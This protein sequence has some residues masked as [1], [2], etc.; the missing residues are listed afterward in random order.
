MNST[1]DLPPEVISAIQA[2]QKIKAIKLLRGA[3]G[4]GLK[5]AKDAVD[6]YLE[7]NP[8]FQQPQANTNGLVFIIFVLLLGY[9]IYRLLA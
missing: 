9:V 5:D 2:G 8:S 3:K 4:L 6:A 1:Q 7:A